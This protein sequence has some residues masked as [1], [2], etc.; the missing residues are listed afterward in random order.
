[1]VF[2][3]EDEDD[4]ID[5]DDGAVDDDHALEEHI[6]HQDAAYVRKRNLLFS[7]IEI[8]K[9]EKMDKTEVDAVAFREQFHRQHHHGKKRR[10]AKRNKWYCDP[11]TGKMQRVCPHL[12]NWWLD[13]VQNP[14]PD[15]PS[16]NK[17]F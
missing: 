7:L 5:D 8:V 6:A 15:C 13:Y 4:L 2:L 10:K 1:M 3:G 17:V 9:D 16:W 12:C 14:E 11:I